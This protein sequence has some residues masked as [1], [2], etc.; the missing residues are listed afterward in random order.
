MR[1]PQFKARQVIDKWT[2]IECLGTGGNGEVWRARDGA[3]P[4]VALKILRNKT[5]RSEPYERF[6]REV[7]AMREMA[8]RRDVLP[9]LDASVPEIVSKYARAWLAMPIAEDITRAL[10]GAP[11]PE[12]V[13]AFASFAG[14]L[15][16]LADQG[17]AHRDVKPANLYRYQGDWCVG[18]FGLIV[19]PTDESI[20]APGATIGPMHFMAPEVL[21]ATATDYH[22]ADAYSLCKSLWVVATD[23]R[24]PPPGE[25]PADRPGTRLAD[26]VAH[27]GVD[28]LDYLIERGT[29]HRPDGRPSL[30]EIADDLAVWAERG[31]MPPLVDLGDVTLKLRKKLAKQ[32]S[33][34]DLEQQRRQ[35]LETIIRVLREAMDPLYQTIHSAHPESVL[36]ADHYAQNRLQWRP[37]L[38]VPAVIESVFAAV[39]IHARSDPNQWVFRVAIGVEQLPD[40][41]VRLTGLV[42]FSRDGL[43]CD[44]AETLEEHPVPLGSIAA[45]QAAER[46][47]A[48]LARLAPVWLD[49]FVSELP[50]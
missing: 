35:D 42:G 40:G 37:G 12:C 3:G 31:T 43:L 48:E 5:P 24:W 26:F 30:R 44:V 10:P 6:S 33:E 21:A 46:V 8:H 47:A 34:W 23:Q 11:L 7:D 22:A 15:A 1:P 14:T 2:L 19:A 20:T 17:I 38:G 16:D 9:L 32:R 13:A 4:D 50:D 29:R 49:R 18:D 41:M 25:I 28:L 27:P 39:R 36:D 45:H